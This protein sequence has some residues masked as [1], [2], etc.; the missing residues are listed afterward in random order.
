MNSLLRLPIGSAFAGLDGDLL[1]T[2][3]YSKCNV[4]L[5]SGE[6]TPTCLPQ[7]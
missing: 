1:V 3:T 7:C 2:Y 5:R 4:V 6:F